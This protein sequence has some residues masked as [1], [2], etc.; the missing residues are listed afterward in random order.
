MP[1]S[2][3]L[4]FL[5]KLMVRLGGTFRNHGISPERINLVSCDDRVHVAPVICWENVYGEFT[6]GFIQKG[7]NVIFNITNE[8][9]W[10]N[11]PG[12]KMFKK[13]AQVRAIETRRSIVRS[14]NTGISAII[15][16]KG[17]TMEQLTWGIKGT[18]K[19]S[20]HLNDDM[21][22]YARHGDYLGKVFRIPALGFLLA[23]AISFITRKIGRVKSTEL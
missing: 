20:V 18:V 16:Q 5:H 21:T 6:T 14:A 9:W 15:N 22:F 10:G 3:R 12:H 11:T 13:Y 7:A 23:L 1:Y 4:K 2:N 17:E 8:G 19:G